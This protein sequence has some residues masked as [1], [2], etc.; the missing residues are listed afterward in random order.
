MLTL[1]NNYNFFQLRELY[2][3]ENRD[4]GAGTL[5]NYVFKDLSELV[6]LEISSCTLKYV[7]LRYVVPNLN[8][9][10]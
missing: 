9:S 6:K 10:I 3:S 5:H 8:T 4:L 7:S 2:L 1:F